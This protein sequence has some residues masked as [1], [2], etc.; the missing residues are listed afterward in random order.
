MSFLFLPF[1]VSGKCSILTFK[2][3][4]LAT[5]LATAELKLRSMNCWEPK[6]SKDRLSC[7]RSPCIW[8]MKWRQFKR[9]VNNFFR[10]V[11]IFFVRYGY[12]KKSILFPVKNLKSSI[13]ICFSSNLFE[14]QMFILRSFKA[15]LS[16]S[17]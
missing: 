11:N 8:S 16:D 10:P 2:F 9:P 1:V 12:W 15:K 6:D 17:I 4:D 7:S 5:L 3:L 13:K 14:H